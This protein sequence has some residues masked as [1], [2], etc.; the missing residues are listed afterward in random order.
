MHYYQFNIGDYA[1]HAGHL[2]EMEDLGFRRLLDL[3]YL[4]E[5]PLP[6]DMN[7]LC[8]LIRM[9]NFEA[10]IIVILDE[11]FDLEDD[12]WHN[13]RADE[14]IA[15]YQS[16]ADTARANGAKGGRP[17]G[18]TKPRITQP[19]IL[20]NPE[21]PT[22]QPDRKLNNKQEPL[23]I[24]QEPVKENTSS[25][26]KADPIPYQQIVDSYHR[27]LPMMPGVQKLTESRKRHIKA[28]WAEIVK[29]GK[30]V[31]YF[32]RFFEHVSHSDFLKTGSFCNLEWLMKEANHLKVIE[33]NY[34]NE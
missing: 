11:F 10:E 15:R 5:S 17:K 8:R 12:S 34:H 33:G 28:R 6:N 16:K 24:N 19:V 26:T 4:S 29:E 21:K 18:T 7:K 3:Y 27:N 9:R 31:G 25:S 14:E 2:T 22:L 20:A 30:D 23:T 32:D 1:S 13:K